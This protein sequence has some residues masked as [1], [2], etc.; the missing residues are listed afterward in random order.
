M[1]NHSVRSRPN[2]PRGN[3]RIF[4]L[5]VDDQLA[6]LFEK[7]AIEYSEKYGCKITK[8]EIAKTF[9]ELSALEFL[10]MDT[11]LGY[12]LRFELLS[13]LIKHYKDLERIH[14]EG[15]KAY[16]RSKFYLLQDHE[17]ILDDGTKIKLDRYARLKEI[18][19][20][21]S[22]EERMAILASLN[23]KFECA[24]RIEEAYIE[25]AELKKKHDKLLS[26]EELEKREKKLRTP[27]TSDVY[28]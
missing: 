17:R 20:Q 5:R 25:Y 22:E 1:S 8:S 26:L 10:S 27:I 24:S 4:T 15:Y 23:A 21:A 3:S 16:L 7:V 28:F 14:G 11:T 18:L 9:L 19:H 2:K 13:R 6:E 12:R